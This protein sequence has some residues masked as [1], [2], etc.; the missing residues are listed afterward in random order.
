MVFF[1]FRYR[2]SCFFSFSFM[3]LF[4]CLLGQRDGSKNVFFL[5]VIAFIQTKTLF[6]ALPHNKTSFIFRSRF[7]FSHVHTSAFV[8]AVPIGFVYCRTHLIVALILPLAVC[9]LPFS[10]YVPYREMKIRG[11]R[12]K[13]E[14]H[15][16]PF[17]W[18]FTAALMLWTT[19]TSSW[20]DLHELRLGLMTE[21]NHK[22]NISNL[23][24]HRSAKTSSSNSKLNCS[25]ISHWIIIITAIGAKNRNVKST[26]FIDDE[27][28][29][30]I[31]R[32]TWLMTFYVASVAI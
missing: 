31:N 5:S 2:A 3:S 28:K 12:A 21:T 24:S 18:L 1:S 8:S 13:Y 27:K 19:V 29:T 11:K 20:V 14:S 30:V 7:V 9:R 4:F 16:T 17:H 6:V 32:Y 23:K 10:D 15:R 26:M 22:I 25:N